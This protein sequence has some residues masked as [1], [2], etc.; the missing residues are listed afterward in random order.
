M[1]TGITERNQ[2][3]EELINL[4]YSMKYI[5]DWQPKTTLYRHREAFNSEGTITDAVGTSVVNVPGN[6]DYVL[7][8][9]RIGL[10]PWEPSE[11]CECQW[12]VSRAIEA[13]EEDKAAGACSHCDYVGNA[14]TPRG[15][16]SQIADHIKKEHPS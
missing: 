11:S 12:C 4:G 2:I 14:P 15:V 9:A 8:K 3:K 13:K 1:V 10:F 5:D 7:R 16:R 6:P